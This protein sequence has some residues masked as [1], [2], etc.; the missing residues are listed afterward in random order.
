MPVVLGVVAGHHDD[1]LCEVGRS[2]LVP[3]H[4]DYSE[5]KL[6]DI[7]AETLTKIRG[8]DSSSGS[9]RFC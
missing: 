9:A 5:N 1:L 6:A 8:C 7:S 4:V 3:V 2:L